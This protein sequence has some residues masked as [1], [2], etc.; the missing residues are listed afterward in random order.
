MSSGLQTCSCYISR[1]HLYLWS[2]RYNVFFL[3][4]KVMFSMADVEKTVLKFHILKAKAVSPPPPPPSL[5]VFRFTS[6]AWIWCISASSSLEVV[7]LDCCARWSH[8]NLSNTIWAH[9]WCC[10]SRR[11]WV[12]SQ[13]VP[14]PP[15][16]HKASAMMCAVTCKRFGKPWK[17]S[18]HVTLLLNSRRCRQ[19]KC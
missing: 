4:W 1:P 6:V 17:L 11:V 7:I 16:T 19:I 13:N 12:C 15:Q 8:F 14:F 10:G 2:R 3:E 18:S 5:T 9:A